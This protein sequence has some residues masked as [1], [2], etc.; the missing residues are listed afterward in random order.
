MYSRSHGDCAYTMDLCNAETVT[1]TLMQIAI[2]YDER[3]LSYNIARSFS[4]L[5]NDFSRVEQ[6][7]IGVRIMDMLRILQ[8][9]LENVTHR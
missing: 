6:N 8:V 9:N 2:M 5:P 7:G 1:S 4:R 3:F